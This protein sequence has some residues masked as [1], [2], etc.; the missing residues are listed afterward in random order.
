MKNKVWNILQ[1]DI[2]T[3]EGQKQIEQLHD[4]IAR[5]FEKVGKDDMQI[6]YDGICTKLYPTM[7]ILEKY[8][9]KEYYETEN[10]KYSFSYNC[11]GAVTWVGGCKTGYVT[12]K[13]ENEARIKIKELM[14]RMNGEVCNEYF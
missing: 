1:K 14:E 5:M 8:L 13:N 3:E 2:Y 11:K 6:F 7:D 12:A 9:D 10:K 4:S